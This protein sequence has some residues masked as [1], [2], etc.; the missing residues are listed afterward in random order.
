MFDQTA[1]VRSPAPDPLQLSLDDLGTP[2]S[3]VTFCVIDLETTGGSAASCGITEIGAVKLR[4]GEC[5]GTFQTLVNPGCAIPPE[6]TV[7]TEITN[8][9]VMPAPRIEAVLPFCLS[10]LV[11]PS[12]S[13]TTSDSIFR[14]CK[15]LLNATNDRN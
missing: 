14:L 4:G 5:I 1:P 11:M 15:P 10:S 3:Q 2:L 8:S 13:D 9:M 6:I 12:L 7:L